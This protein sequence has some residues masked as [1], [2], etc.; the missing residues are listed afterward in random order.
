MLFSTL[1]RSHSLNSPKHERK[2]HWD[3][4][5]HLEELLAKIWWISKIWISFHVAGDLTLSFSASVLA[6]EAGR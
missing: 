2:S 1:N 4:W 5:R 6:P 3:I